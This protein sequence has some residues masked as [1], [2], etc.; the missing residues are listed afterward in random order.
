[1]SLSPR[2]NSPIWRG[3]PLRESSYS[4]TDQ[5]PAEGRMSDSICMAVVIKFSEL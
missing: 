5:W 1:M 2:R 3:N 4:W